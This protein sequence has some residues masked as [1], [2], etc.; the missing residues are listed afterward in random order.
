MDNLRVFVERLK[1][2]G[3]TYFVLDAGWYRQYA[4]DGREFPDKDDAYVVR[5]DAF[6]RPAPAPC[7]FPNGIAPVAA[8]C[9][10]AGVKFGIHMMR[11]IPKVAVTANTTVL[12]PSFR[13]Q[14]IANPTDTCQ[15]CPDNVGLDMSKPGAPSYCDSIIELLAGWGVDFIKYDDIVPAPAEVGAVANAI[16]RCGREIVLSLSPGNEHKVNG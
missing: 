3:Y 10:A 6:D 15:W 13:A 14:D 4:L 8:A 1:P 12:G 16:E 5:H 7:F 11:G 9:H 2:H